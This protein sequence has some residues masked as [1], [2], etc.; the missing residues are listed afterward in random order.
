LIGRF[1]IER[2]QAYALAAKYILSFQDEWH[3]LSSTG[4]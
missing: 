1:F 3:L 2:D 4:R